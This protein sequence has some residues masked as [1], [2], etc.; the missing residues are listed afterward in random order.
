ME[1]LSDENIHNLPSS[2]NCGSF[3]LSAYGQSAADNSINAAKFGGSL[4]SL[5]WW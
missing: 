2:P 5:F 1:L 3:F 4:G